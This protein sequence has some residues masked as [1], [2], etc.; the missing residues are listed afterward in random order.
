VV[1]RECEKNPPLE[2][3]VASLLRYVKPPNQ[4]IQQT[5]KTQTPNIAQLLG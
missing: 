4:F 5:V 2:G 3:N 1:T